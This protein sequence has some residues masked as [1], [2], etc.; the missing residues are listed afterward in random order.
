MNSYLSRSLT[1]AFILS[2]SAV[3]PAWGAAQVG[4]SVESATTDAIK[5]RV[6][7][8][9][10]GEYTAKF[11][12]SLKGTGPKSVFRF[13]DHDA[14]GRHT[15]TGQFKGGRRGLKLCLGQSIGGSLVNPPAWTQICS[16]VLA[17]RKTAKPLADAL[18][19]TVKRRKV[20][21]EALRPLTGDFAR[22]TLTIRK[23]PKAKGP[24]T[25]KASRGVKILGAKTTY[26]PEL[27]P[28]ETLKSA[29]IKLEDDYHRYAGTVKR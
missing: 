6:S 8:L 15:W 22:V 23:N 1:L 26:K 24:R 21:L 14:Q 9:P 7:P 27:R 13:A 16:K 11:S 29:K 20:V 17:P 19:V 12:T 18:K 5:Y 4:L 25:R 10:G 3:A 2:L 28:K